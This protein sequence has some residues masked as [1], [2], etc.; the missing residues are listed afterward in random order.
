MFSLIARRSCVA[1]KSTVLFK[2]ASRFNSYEAIAPPFAPLTNLELTFLPTAKGMRPT[3]EDHSE[4]HSELI[5]RIHTELVAEDQNAAQQFKESAEI[6]FPQL[7]NRDLNDLVVN[8]FQELMQHQVITVQDCYAH[9]AQRVSQKC[10]V[11]ATPFTPEEYQRYGIET[12]APTLAHP[13]PER[14]YPSPNPFELR[15][16]RIK[17]T[18]SDEAI[19]EAFSKYG[20]VKSVVR[21][22]D[23]TYEM[24]YV[25]VTFVSVESAAKAIKNN[26]DVVVDGRRPNL[27]LELDD[28]KLINMDQLQG[29]LKEILE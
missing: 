6:L 21:K 4:A 29:K 2:S 22:F 8:P 13:L 20:A 25:C 27:T 1:R 14:L 26:P 23:K 5:K 16:Y 3:D 11:E 24:N 7:K 18:T 17:E 28:T 19:K 10:E 15:A 12:S 9:I